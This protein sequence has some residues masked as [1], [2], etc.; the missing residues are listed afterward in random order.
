M[1]VRTRL[2][3]IVLPILFYLVLGVAS[4]Y[5][6]WGA[7]NGEHGLKAKQKY[8]SEAELLQTELAALKEERARWGRRVAA[9][10]PDSVDRDLL[11]EE[12]HAKLDRVA[13]DEVVIFTAPDPRR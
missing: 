4:G 10:R 8:D 1:V 6:V 12:A 7:S 3:S 13:K 11:D 5:L 9:L 2:R